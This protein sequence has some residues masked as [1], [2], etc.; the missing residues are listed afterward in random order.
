ME[1]YKTVILQSHLDMVHQKNDETE[2]DFN[3]CHSPFK[4][5]ILLLIFNNWFEATSPKHKII[6]GFKNLIK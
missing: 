4:L 1:N 6:L 5:I 3:I 2:F